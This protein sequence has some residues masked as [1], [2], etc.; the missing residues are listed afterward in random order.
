MGPYFRIPAFLFLVVT[1][2]LSGC[3]TGTS[4]RLTEAERTIE[5]QRTQIESLNQK[6]SEL[7][8]K[9]FVQEMSKDQFKSATFDPSD[10][11]FERLDT[12]VGTFAVSIQ[13]ITAHADGVRVRLHVG[14]LTTATVIGGKFKVKWGTRM[15]KAEGKGW[16]A[17]YTGW[18]KSLNEKEINFLEELRPGTWNNVTLILPGLPPDKFGYLELQM[19][20][21]Q[22][23]LLVPRS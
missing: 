15:P 11:G 7:E 2:G 14:N 17:S 5:A 9:V 18:Q 1:V 10:R 6:V 4:A 22:I 23:K 13:G 3:D 16:A 8:T 21:S 19:E 12:S 20:S